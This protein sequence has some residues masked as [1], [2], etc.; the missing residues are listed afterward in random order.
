M[1]YD[2]NDPYS[3][4]DPNAPPPRD[5]GFPVGGVG[6]IGPSIPGYPG[7]MGGN[8]GVTGGFLP[9]TGPGSLDDWMRRN[10]GQNPLGGTGVPPGPGANPYPAPASAPFN[11]EQA[12]NS[13][14][15]G[16][17]G[18]GE[19]GA[20]AWAA[21]NGVPYNGGDTISLPNGGGQIDIIGNYQGGRGNPGNFRNNWTPAGGNGPNPGGQGGGGGGGGGFGG[22]GG[23]GGFGA[24]GPL[25]AEM[26][27]QLLAL[28]KRGSSPFDVN[29][30]E[31]QAQYLPVRNALERQG[32]RS[33]EQAVERAAFEGSSFGGGNV[34]D[35][36]RSINERVGEQSGQALGGMIEQDVQAK[37]QDLM[38]ALQLANSI[39]AREQAAQIQRE[40]A[41]LES[42][43]RYAQLG[44]QGQQFNAALGQRTSQWNDT[45]G[46]ERARFEADQNRAAI[47]AGLA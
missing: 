28:M 1:A 42:G 16:Q 6:G 43:F 3:E 8:T 31:L 32:Q 14:M 10:P 35:I 38:G 24:G 15:S 36:S 20:R 26:R 45:Y 23:G 13:W 39:G 11:Y 18:G 12:R 44:Q 19:A 4:Y 17:Y 30:P 47:L 37:R 29:A 40:L 5:T 34:G 27:A 2:P 33:R 9:Q 41:Q 22:G 46:L 7:P 21:A 25:D